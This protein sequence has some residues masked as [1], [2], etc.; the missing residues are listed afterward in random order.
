STSPMVVRV[1]A[2][3]WFPDVAQPA[4]PRA[5]PKIR[6]ADRTA[7]LIRGFIRFSFSMSSCEDDQRKGLKQVPCPRGSFHELSFRSRNLKTIGF[8]WPPSINLWSVFKP[9]PKA[10]LPKNKKSDLLAPYFFTLPTLRPPL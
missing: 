1:S 6:P 3:L 4:S 10:W 7:L 5:A 2:D 9:E 8:F